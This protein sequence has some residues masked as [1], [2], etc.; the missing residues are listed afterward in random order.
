MLWILVLHITAVLFW[1]AAQLYLPALIAG[2][3]SNKTSGI[4][5]LQTK[6]MP[7]ALP[8]LKPDIPRSLP[9]FVF[10][11]ISTPAALIAIVSGTVIFVLNRTL[12]VWF[13]AKLSLVTLLVITHALSGWLLLH[14]EAN[15]GPRILWISRLLAVV[16]AVLMTA[17]IWMVLSKPSPE[18]F[19]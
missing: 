6:G 1:C 10:T 7:P 17:I 4:S 5:T 19:Q 3:G 12:D 15:P 18:F 11:K 9:R 16:L 14:A 8:E 2:L 13:L